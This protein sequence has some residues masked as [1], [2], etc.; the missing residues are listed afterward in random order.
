MDAERKGVREGGASKMNIERL[1]K[2]EDGLKQRFI[3]RGTTPAFMNSLRRAIMTYVPTLAIEDV[4]FRKN[5]SALYDEV[6]A[7]RLGLIPLK[8]D[9][10]S[11]ELPSECSCKGEGC[12]KCQLKITLD[13][14][15]PCTVYAGD[16]KISDPKIKPVYPKIPIVKL[17]KNQEL[18]FEAIAIL[19]LGKEHAK[20]SPGHAYYQG[21]P[22][23][24]IGKC[25]NPEEVKD[26]CPKGVF[27]IKDGNLMINE[28]K[29]KDCDL[30]RACSDICDAI[31]V[32]GSRTDFIFSIESWGQL[33]VD[34]IINYALDY[35]KKTTKDFKKSL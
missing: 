11:Y 28:E 32:R 34:E 7:H 6:I 5:S 20:W 3:I 22:E 23:I 2:S 9:L 18:A 15:G 13:K 16:L 10:E 4:E 24:E 35:L 17:L 25:A 14:K 33:D 19:G 12:S 30:C 21:Y 1:Y 8:T 26:A 29:I 27:L 31:K